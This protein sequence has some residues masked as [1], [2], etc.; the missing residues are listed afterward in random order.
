MRNRYASR[1]A[2]QAVVRADGTRHCAWCGDYIDP[3]DWCDD[4]QRAGA[5][6]A[7]R[8]GPHRRLRKRSDAAFCDHRCRSANASDTNGS[9]G[10]R[11]ESWYV[12]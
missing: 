4:C 6:C 11:R 8:G 12:A 7:T 10:R 9:V 1:A 5:P 3:I 2:A